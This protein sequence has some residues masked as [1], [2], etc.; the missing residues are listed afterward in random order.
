MESVESKPQ[1]PTKDENLQHGGSCTICSRRN[2]SRRQKKGGIMD[3]T[4]AELEIIQEALDVWLKGWRWNYH[5]HGAYH[6]ECK[7]IM[8]KLGKGA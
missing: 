8:R 4:K 7:E 5:V 6:R 1:I 3:I 2:Q